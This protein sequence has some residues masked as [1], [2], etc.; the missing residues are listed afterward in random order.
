MK[1]LI[2]LLVSVLAVAAVASAQPRALGIRA[3]YGGEIS[4]QHGGGA[5]F[6]EADLG[7]LGYNHGIYLTGIYDF[8]LG[9]A[10][11]CNFYAGPGVAL[12]F[13]NDPQANTSGFNAGVAGQLGIEFE[14]PSIPMNISLDWRP[15]Y[16][17]MY[18][19]FGWAGFALGIRYRF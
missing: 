8:I 4:Y 17:F 7:F 19:G 18:G 10:G 16:S 9:S 6:L 13:W 2:V 14:I 3:G 1:K 11:I 5:G 12:G 15:T